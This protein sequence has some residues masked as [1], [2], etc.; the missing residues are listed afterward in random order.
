MLKDA[1]EAERAALSAFRY[2]ANTAFLHSD[3]RLMPRRRA[4][5]S[6]WNYVGKGREG[7]AQ[8]ALAAAATA[9]PG[10]PCCVSYWLNK[11][12]NLPPSMPDLFVTL[13]PAPGLRPAP[14]SLLA[15][16]NYSHPQYTRGTVAA[17]AQL[18]TLQG[19]RS[20]WFC[21]AYLGYGF[22]EDGLTSGLRVAHKI[23]GIQPPWWSKPLYRPRTGRAGAG[24]NASSGA[25][26][27][28]SPAQIFADVTAK[29][30]C[31]GPYWEDNLGNGGPVGAATRHVSRLLDGSRAAQAEA[32]LAA[33]RKASQ[34]GA[35]ASVV[36]ANDLRGVSADG[37]MQGFVLNSAADV[38]L[39]Y[40]NHIAAGVERGSATPAAAAAPGRRAGL[41]DGGSMEDPVS[42][43]PS[44][45]GTPMSSSAPSS[46]GS[47]L[48]P[49]L[50][51]RRAFHSEAVGAAIASAL[52]A[53]ATG[54]RTAQLS[55]GS[56]TVG[57]L[58]TRPGL[59]GGYTG[60]D[61]PLH[62]PS[63][64]SGVAAW[65][66]E[67]IK[68]SMRTAVSGPVLSFMR[69]YIRQGCILLRSPDGTEEAVGDLSAAFGMRCELKVHSWNFFS[70]VAAEADLGLA[71][72]FIAGEWSTDDLTALF[73]I[74]IANRD[75]AGLSARSLWTSWIG[76]TVNYL[77]YAVQLDNSL[78]GSRKNI[79]SHYDLSNDLFVSFLDTRTL[80]YSCGFFETERRFV[81]EA[82]ICS[83]PAGRRAAAAA[84]PRTPGPALTPASP[85]SP[86]ALAPD[87]V[88]QANAAE[89][90]S[91]EQ[92][93]QI[94]LNAWPVPAAAPSLECAE[95]NY[96]IVA[97]GRSVASAVTKPY[98]VVPPPPTPSPESVEA[99]AP[100]R[101]EVLFKGSLEEA[102]ERKLDHLISR[103]NV[104]RTDRVLD[105]G[106]GWGG[107]SIR[108]AETVGCRVHGITLSKEQHA[109]AL[110]RVRARGLEHLVSFE[111]VDYRDFAAAHAGEFDKIISVE[112]IEAVGANYFG[113]FMAALDRLL[114]PDGVIV[115]QAITIPEA[116]F[117]E[118][119]RTTDFIN[120]II[121]PGGALPCIAALSAAMMQRTNLVLDRV[122]QFN[123]HYAETL[124]RWRANFNAAYAAGVVA[125]FDDAFARTWNYYFCYCEAGFQT[126]TLGLQVL[127]FTRPNNSSRVTGVPAGR[128]ASTLGGF[129]N[130]RETPVVVAAGSLD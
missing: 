86:A 96:R 57:E 22:H 111:I 110:E 36:A 112:M 114:A 58:M 63:A 107:L 121:F 56:A 94:T 11:L 50:R 20:T 47:A 25:D 54:P 27:P 2:Q 7:V 21:G 89:R 122:D 51:V 26:K 35:A 78:A 82:E 52:N 30:A 32:V 69:S 113:D 77:S 88:R 127:T 10:E 65:V 130:T 125:G 59:T 108:L 55:G 28:L 62:T 43:Q 41:F 67:S 40:R 1:D 91:L 93:R 81:R 98:S 29:K 79:Q 104:Q 33:K 38:L 16:F 12:Q 60:Q 48:A 116:R 99:P 119:L 97:S 76:T 71:R 95:A 19:Q 103:A 105:L 66:W 90:V 118:Y 117:A 101:V 31:G 109:L 13:N 45:A 123:L 120:T 84:P 5:W 34:P 74:F 64:Y 126:Q 128:E 14:G 102:Q 8:A 61:T 53:A 4:C 87:Q 106:F 73:N 3:D 23:T 100:D 92:A 85:F 18:D 15:V 24:T 9:A 49:E 70:R 17:Q 42:V 83:T 80:M 72:S 75:N 115:I 129:T 37:D 6:S 44:A 39:A 68:L 124:R 46:S